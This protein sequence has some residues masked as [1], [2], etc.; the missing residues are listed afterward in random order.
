M[1]TSRALLSGNFGCGSIGMP[2]PLSRTV[3][4]LP[5]AELE[6]DPGGMA[7][8]RLVHG[9]VQHLGHQMMQ[10]PLVGAADIHARAPADRLQALQH[11]DVVRRVAVAA[12]ALAGKIE[13]VGHALRSV[14][15]A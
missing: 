7:G 9:V 4:R 15:R 11:L 14:F 5:A 12:G 8:H 3:S 1:M 6:L 13:Q 2:R 10:R